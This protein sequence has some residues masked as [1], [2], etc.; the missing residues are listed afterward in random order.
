MFFPVI[1]CEPPPRPR[2]FHADSNAQEGPPVASQVTSR[3]KCTA[4][5]EDF[6]EALESSGIIVALRVAAM[7]PAAKRASLDRN[8]D[9][10]PVCYAEVAGPGEGPGALFD[11]A[12]QNPARERRRQKLQHRLSRLRYTVREEMVS[13]SKPSLERDLSRLILLKSVA[14]QSAPD[15]PTHR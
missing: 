14:V 10:M 8:N 7:R 4:A 9:R 11:G 13:G 1:R 2:F 15:C 6:K 5:D 12:Q 3:T